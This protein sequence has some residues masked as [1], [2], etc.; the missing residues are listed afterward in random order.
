MTGTSG[1]IGKVFL[2]DA[3]KK[4]YKVIDIL[5]FKNKQNNELNLL[6]KKYLKSYK[7]IFFNKNSEIEKKLRNLNVDYFINFATLYKNSHNHSEIPE[8]LNSNLVFPTTVLDIVYKKIQ[9]MI[10]FG[11]MMQHND[12]KSYIPKNFYASTKSAFEM[13]INFYALQNQKFKFYNL[14]FYESFSEIDSRKKLIPTLLKNYKNNIYTKI[15]SKQLEINIIHINDIIKAVYIILDNHF[16]NG[17][18]CLKQNKNIKI[19]KLINKI[20]QQSNKKIKIQYLNKK[21]KKF[22]KSKI[23][24][25]PNWKPDILIEKKILKKFENAYN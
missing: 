17:S 22:K 1:F 15:L 16:K 24:V 2:H 20:N 23:K 4:G 6:R 14:K 12:G 10:N 9:K 19:S 13:I 18:Y 11:T 5:R 7:S 8:F 21:I 3:L 25:L